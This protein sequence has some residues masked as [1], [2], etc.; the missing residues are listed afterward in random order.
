MTPARKA[1]A[2]ESAP[3]LADALLTLKTAEEVRDFLAD[4][5]TPAEIE[6][7]EERWGLVQLLDGGSLSYR[8]ISAKTG[9]STTTIGRV[10]RFL[11]K[12]R[13]RGYRTALD[14]LKNRQE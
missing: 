1:A 10:A 14:R 11:L 3:S 9:A 8:D 7:L 12:E 6:A 2:T 13:H 4:L 5:C